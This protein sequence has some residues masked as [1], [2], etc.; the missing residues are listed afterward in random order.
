MAPLETLPPFPF[1]DQC[2]LQ[3]RSFEDD[4]AGVVMAGFNMESPCK[5]N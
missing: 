4:A 3:W 1:H 2:T 5:S